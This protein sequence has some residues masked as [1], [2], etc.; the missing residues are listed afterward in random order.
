MVEVGVRCGSCGGDIHFVT[1]DQVHGSGHTWALASIC[2]N[3]FDAHF[4][5]SGC[6]DCGRATHPAPNPEE[7]ESNAHAS[8]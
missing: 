4:I 2:L 6:Q 8:T 3:C 7:G 5:A 1:C